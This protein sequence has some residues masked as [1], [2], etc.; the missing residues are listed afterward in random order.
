MQATRANAGIHRAPRKWP[1][2]P[3]EPITIQALQAPNKPS[4]TA[5]LVAL[6]SLAGLVV[7]AIVYSRVGN[8]SS[9]L[10]IGFLAVSGL[11]MLVSGGTAIVQQR[12]AK[13]D[14]RE[15]ARRYA[16]YLDET[17][18]TIATLS[19]E[20]YTVR[21]AN[22]PSIAEMLA[23]LSRHPEQVWQRQPSDPDFLAARVGMG[24]TTPWLQVKLAENAT[25][26]ALPAKERATRQQQ[27]RARDLA[28]THRLAHDAPLTIPL[29][30]HAA[31]ALLSGENNVAGASN[32][33]CAVVGQVALHHAPNDVQLVVFAPERLAR[34]WEWVKGLP[35]VE[36]AQP[37]RPS[38]S[39][40]QAR[41]Q[42]RLT[43]ASQPDERKQRLTGLLAELSRRQ[44]A[45][46]AR[47][48]DGGQ[49]PGAPL[50]HILIVVD[51]FADGARPDVNDP[52]QSPALALALQ[53]GKELGAT[54]L[55]VHAA[56][57]QAPAQVTLAVNV[58]QRR[59]NALGPEPA[60][61]TICETLDTFDPAS[62][63]YI[64]RALDNLELETQAALEFP[65]VVRLLPL[66][67]PPI[68]IAEDYPIPEV[69]RRS[70]QRLAET[71]GKRAFSIP[72]GVM[73]GNEPLHLD[74]VADGPHGLLIGQTGSGKSE[75]LRSIIAAL[76]VQ[77]APD[78]ANFVLVDYKGGL[79]FDA[80][81]A[82][83]H[84]VAYLTNMVQPGQTTRF[85]AMLEAEIVRRQAARA[86][87]EPQPELFVIIDEFAEMVSRR[88]VNDTSDVVL[89]N[90]LSIA[91]LG[92]ELGVHLLF[93]AQRPEGSVIQRLRGYVQYR[94]C[95]RTNTEEDSRD[96]INTPDAA[97]L[98]VESPGRGYLQRG[99]NE[100]ILFQ[101]ARVT[102]PTSQSGTVHYSRGGE[103]VT[104]SVPSGSGAT[105]DLIIAERM[106]RLTGAPTA[107]RWPVPLPEPTLLEPTPLILLAGGTPPGGARA[108]DAESHTSLR[109]LEA[110]LGLYDRPM[111]QRQDWYIADLLGHDGR[112]QGGPLLVM[113]DLN[114]GKTTTLQT[115]L[116]ALAQAHGP[117]QTRWFILNP[118]GSLNDFRALPQ[119]RDYNDP[120]ITN[121]IDGQDTEEFR[122]FANRFA[123]MAQQDSPARPAMLLVIDDYDELATQFSQQGMLQKD[124]QN[125]ATM[126]IRGRNERRLYLAIAAARASFNELPPALIGNM[127]TRIA[128]YM[129]DRDHVRNVISGRTPAAMDAIPGRGLIQTRR[130]LDAIQ[131]A[132]P[133]AGRN[134]AERLERLDNKIQRA[135]QRWQ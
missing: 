57:Q 5:V 13:V 90:L 62:G 35:V 58:A 46:A 25:S 70:S 80:Y 21:R 53:H 103:G 113:G 61:E 93:A 54:V 48:N 88:S 104:S 60:A 135:A 112:M 98:P 43:L 64:A 12:A 63:Q 105:V 128:L 130:S 101:A 118:N 56:R 124:L 84:T 36:I 109:A 126:A 100:L 47:R 9:T 97:R 37:R 59:I 116:L 67:D 68:N 2:I 74:F 125:L 95:L 17:E 76:A 72:L 26:F 127:A 82:L 42:R 29:R 38:Q 66:L 31:V 18:K 1:Y 32:L 11:S 114:A 91:R 107:N 108:W 71:K 41:K 3:D 106:R 121:V 50:P 89:D 133:V 83:P 85:L 129:S 123:R 102:L 27:E 19:A 10:V 92:R 4:S 34:Q 23:T 8:G 65:S 131:I 44:Q 69:W 33:A 45:L 52:L 75:L 14:A 86:Q 99:D 132:S 24:D 7:A 49:Q 77:Y 81:G 16:A 134:D 20:E 122:A 39:D 51:S 111:E 120:S 55:S 78:Q 94:I 115:L 30:D 6:A 119:T 96:V 79:A 117:S 73:L 40:E 22:D 110:P 28:E 15:L 87:N